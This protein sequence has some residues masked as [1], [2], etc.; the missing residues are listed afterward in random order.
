M[1]EQQYQDPK[2]KFPALEATASSLAYR[3]QKSKREGKDIIGS[4]LGE[5]LQIEEELLAERTSLAERL[6][7]VREVNVN[8][9]LQDSSDEGRETSSRLHDLYESQQ[10][11]YCTTFL[12][13]DQ[14]VSSAPCVA[15]EDPSY[16]ENKA[17]TVLPEMKIDQKE[18]KQEPVVLKINLRRHRRSVR[19]LSLRSLDS[20]DL[21]KSSGTKLYWNYSDCW[22]FPYVLCAIA[23]PYRERLSRELQ[24]EGQ[25]Q[26]QSHTLDS[27][28]W[29]LSSP[30]GLADSSHPSRH[31]AFWSDECEVG[32]TRDGT[33]NLH[34][35][36]KDKKEPMTSRTE[37]YKKKEMNQ[38]QKNTPAKENLTTS[39]HTQ[40]TECLRKMLK[41][42]QTLLEKV[43][44]QVDQERMEWKQITERFQGIQQKI[45]NI[46]DTWTLHKEE[47]DRRELFQTVEIS[48]V[49]QDTQDKQNS[50]L[51]TMC[52]LPGSEMPFNSSVSQTDMPEVSTLPL[53]KHIQENECLRNPLVTSRTQLT[54]PSKDTD[55]QSVERHQIQL[56]KDFEEIL[57]KIT[58]FSDECIAQ[59]KEYYRRELAFQ[60]QLNQ[61]LKKTSNQQNF[62]SINLDLV[63]SNLPPGNSVPLSD[64]PDVSSTLNE[65]KN[66]QETK[67]LL[68]TDV[69]SWTQLHRAIIE[70]DQQKVEQRKLTE[71]FQKK[72]KGITQSKD[73]LRAPEREYSRPISQS[74]V[75]AGCS[76]ADMARECCHEKEKAP[77]GLAEHSEEMEYRRK[78]WVIQIHIRDSTKEVELE[79]KK[80]KQIT[81]KLQTL[82]KKI[83]QFKD[84]CKVHKKGCSRRELSM[85]GKRS[86][87]QQNTL[88]EH[89]LTLPSKL[90][91]SDSNLQ[92]E[93]SISLS[94]LPKVSPTLVLNSL[95]GNII[96][97]KN[98]G[99][100]PRPVL[101][102]GNRD[103]MSQFGMA[104]RFQKAP[105]HIEDLTFQQ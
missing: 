22:G 50:T 13:D 34:E 35:P 89:D 63:D 76:T 83:I 47:F 14:D 81:E 16:K 105:A 1:S 59:D 39:K 61:L 7:G 48:R 86:Q 51:P 99:I 26:V 4:M 44:K 19:Q 94:D 103:E 62:T 55:P 92:P 40:E 64:M 27:H 54:G 90:E 43:R 60:E 87:I 31:L 12:L 96:P 32:F 100:L 58:H 52:E 91:L 10:P 57:R 95:S 85:K 30:H 74:D 67:C 41:N 68:K 88:D 15:R 82:Q 6:S 101:K 75:P 71:K 9:V 36:K 3:L 78:T 17:T 5:K 11:P 53:D 77:A 73:K 65:A 66:I 97:C 104:A 46:N 72:Q 2:E 8:E 84:K 21:C 69:T 70:L 20:M 18:G 37:K 24:E 93:S 38:L 79:K 45:L 23:V 42:S 33:K 29:I 98:C 56:N 25:N 49:Q 102:P 80:Q 28:N